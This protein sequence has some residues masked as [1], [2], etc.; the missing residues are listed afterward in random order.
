MKNRLRSTLIAL[1]AVVV[2]AA[3]ARSNAD[4]CCGPIVAGLGSVVAA[5]A[6]NAVAVVAGVEA[7]AAAII[8]ALEQVGTKI[9][10]DIA[11]LGGIIQQLLTAQTNELVLLESKVYAAHAKDHANETYGPLSLGPGYCLDADSRVASAAAGASRAAAKTAA[12]DALVDYS[13]EGVERATEADKKILEAPD[14]ALI[15]AALFPPAEPTFD[16]E[17]AEQALDYI[18]LLT[19]PRP[20]PKPVGVHPDSAAAMA[21]ESLLREQQVKMTLA[22]EALTD[23]IAYQ[24]ATREVDD[25]FAKEWETHTEGDTPVIDGKI[26]QRA[27]VENGVRYRIDSLDYKAK[28]A[29]QEQPGLLRELAQSIAISNQLALLRFDLQQREAAISAV[30]LAQQTHDEYDNQLQAIRTYNQGEN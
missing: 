13:K 30:R 21:Y 16:D 3:P 1:I 28:L 17:A 6:A 19:E 22:R 23:L 9:S 24:T 29:Q 27:W 10:V 25:E 11:A 15:A 12:S 8:V 2:I 7:G 5:V 20:A 14:E 18:K 26:S 4:V